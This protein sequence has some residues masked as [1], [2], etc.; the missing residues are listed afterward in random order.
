MNKL[1]TKVYCQTCKNRNNHSILKS[2]IESSSVP[3]DI[4]YEYSFYIVQC[5]GCDTVAFVS[6]YGDESMIDYDE[7]GDRKHFKDVRVYPEEPKEERISKFELHKVQNFDESPE[8]IRVMYF[9]IVKAFNMESYL[10]AAVGLRMLL[11]GICKDLKITDGYSLDDSGVKKLKKNSN[12]EVRSSSL[13]G[14]IN[15]LVDKKLVVQTQANILHQIRE[16]GNTSAHELQ[17]PE[18]KTI[19]QAIDI[20]ERIIEQI[21]ELHKI[22]IV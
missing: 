18:R 12:E 9:Q 16:L 5:M 22:R 19:K 6:E 21:Y 13:E 7:F 10:L 17:T 15:G 8:V 2:H 11:E 4:Q 3:W 1:D 20:L 14:K